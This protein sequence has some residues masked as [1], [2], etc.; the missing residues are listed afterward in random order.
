LL[1][2]YLYCLVG[3]REARSETLHFAE[4]RAT[5][6][7]LVDDVQR[8]QQLVARMEDRIRDLRQSSG[9]Y[10]QEATNRRL[11]ILAILSAIYLPSTLI[12][13]IFGMNFV[14]IPITHL[15][16]GYFFVLAIMIGLVVGQLWFF[17]RRGWFR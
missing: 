14:N 9:N 10:L 11:N 2:D 7:D 13:G 17:Y 3:L 4:V 8:G 5:L 6:Q 16:Y 15:K 12:A 1:E